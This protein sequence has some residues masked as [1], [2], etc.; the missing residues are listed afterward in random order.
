MFST[1]YNYYSF[2]NDDI[3]HFSDELVCGVTVPYKIFIQNKYKMNENRIPNYIFRMSPF[4][5]DTLPIEIR[6]VLENAIEYNPDYVQVYLDD[7]DCEAFLTTHYPDYVSLYHSLIPGAYKSDLVRL[8]LLEHYG[9][10]YNDIGHIYIEPL[11]TIITKDTEVILTNEPYYGRPGI[12]NAL[13][14]FYKNHPLLHEFIIHITNNIKNKSYGS[15][16]LDI[17]G[18]KALGICFMNYFTSHIHDGDY[19]YHHM[20]EKYPIRFTELRNDIVDHSKLFILYNNKPLI[21]TKF[22]NYNIIM[23]SNRKS[24]HYSELW[25]RRMVYKENYDEIEITIPRTIFQTH[26]SM[27]YIQSNPQLVE[28]T[29]SWKKHTEFSYQFYDDNQ[30]R[31]FMKTYFSSIL[32]FYDALPLQVMRADLW[33]YCIIYIY[34]G[35]YADTDTILYKTPELFT[36]HPGKQLVVVP[37]NNVHFCQWV[38]AAPPKSPILKSIIDLSVERMKKIN[39]LECKGEH[40]IHYLTGPGVFTD[41]IISYLQD[42][43]VI[44]PTDSDFVTSYHPTTYARL[45]EGNIYQYEQNKISQMYVFPQ[46]FHIDS[47]KHLHSGNWSNGWTIERNKKLL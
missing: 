37:E 14:A 47:V 10:V 19:T 17:T 6:N 2:Y 4:S 1:L 9:G 11:S 44:I 26:K 43:H 40:I 3:E 30:C 13:L 15:N 7:D 28:A 16:L 12:H 29:T 25:T 31:E 32:D 34:G 5:Y 21:K 18:P 38:F 41:G 35:I 46:S 33:R 20:N 36:T 22:D 39:L 23:Y 45:K 8:C 42:K 27:E 24:L